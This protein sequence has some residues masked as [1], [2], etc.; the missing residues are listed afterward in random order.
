VNRNLYVPGTLPSTSDPRLITVFI[1]PYGSFVGVNGGSTSVPVIDFGRF[2]VTAWGGNNASNTDPCPDNLV[3]I[4]PG[5]IDGRF[6]DLAPQGN[7][8]PNGVC[9]LNQLR[10]CLATL[11]Y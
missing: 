1:V 3:G 6:V 2:Y 8:D 9:D 7:P 11:V 10:P 5:E 4:Q